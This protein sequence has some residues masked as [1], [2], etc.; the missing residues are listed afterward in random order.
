MVEGVGNTVD[1]ARVA[2]VVDLGH[3]DEVVPR[4]EHAR[5][6]DACHIT[7]QVS[8]TILL[9]GIII[10]FVSI[11]TRLISTIILAVPLFAMRIRKLGLG[12]AGFREHR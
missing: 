7:L 1:D 10:D 5:P 6:H 8:T 11:T 9:V 4:V 2:G 12:R 3:E